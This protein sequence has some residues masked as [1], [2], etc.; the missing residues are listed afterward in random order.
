M[1]L[2][3]DSIQRKFKATKGTCC[4]LEPI[5]EDRISVLSL[6]GGKEPNLHKHQLSN[7]GGLITLT[8]AFSRYFVNFHFAVSAEA[9]NI[10]PSYSIILPLNHQSPLHKLKLGSVQN[11]MFSLPLTSV[12]HHLPFMCGAT[13]VNISLSLG[14]LL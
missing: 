14:L 5:T 4:L 9:P 6:C 1:F 10:L 8:Y 3:E 12:R 7:L 2:D 13:L 11:R